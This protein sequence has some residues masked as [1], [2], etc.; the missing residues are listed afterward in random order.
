MKMTI[1]LCLLLVVSS[2][3]AEQIK[4]KVITAVKDVNYDLGIGSKVELTFVEKNEKKEFMFMGRMVGHPELGEEILF[5]DEKDTRILMVDAE[6]MTSGFLKTR[7]QNI[8]SPLEQAGE[9]CAAY[10]LYHYWQQTD[11]VGFKGNGELAPV[12]SKERSRMKFLEESITRYYLG[13]SS[14]F[15]PIMKNFGER[16]GFKCKEKTFEESG[17]AVDYVYNQSL[18]GKSVVMEFYL[19]KE[20]VTSSVEIEDYETKLEVDDRLWIPRKVGERNG[21]GHAIVAAA[22]F[23]SLG[24][25]KVLVLDSN[26]I[27][28]RVWD[29]EKYLGE[30]AAISEMIFHSCD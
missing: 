29:L 7:M 5:L 6:S 15:K 18:T 25:K 23:T 9:T 14:N 8:V 4:L 19:G 1:T 20:M 30:K 2:A 11:L 3:Y 24:R 12:M 28:P 27:E 17:K 26:W 13:R 10:A 21:G 22:A 16:F